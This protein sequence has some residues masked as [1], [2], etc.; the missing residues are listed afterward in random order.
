MKNHKFFE[1]KPLTS[2]GRSQSVASKDQLTLQQIQVQHAIYIDYFFLLV[3]TQEPPKEQK[4]AEA[5]PD[6]LLYLMKDEQIKNRYRMHKSFVFLDKNA[7]NCFGNKYLISLGY[8]EGEK[9]GAEA[10]DHLILK[11][12]DF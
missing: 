1:A 6:Q 2:E 11:I 9:E 12:W 8:E 5:E 4:A 3:G 7:A 10:Q